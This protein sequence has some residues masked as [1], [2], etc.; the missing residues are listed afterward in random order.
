VKTASSASQEEEK[1]AK[2][3][4]NDERKS[5]FKPTKLTHELPIPRDHEEFLTGFMSKCDT[6][7]KKYAFYI[8]KWIRLKTPASKKSIQMNH[9]YWRHFL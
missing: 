2:T 6:Y 9:V 1:K 4:K 8:E 5:E 3:W 7:E